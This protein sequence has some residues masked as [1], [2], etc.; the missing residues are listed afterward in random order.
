MVFVINV[1]SPS[2]SPPLR[3]WLD[4]ARQVLLFELGG[5]M[6][7]TPLFSWASGVP[8]QQ[9]LVLIVGLAAIAAIWN[10]VFNTG[11]DWLEGRLTGKPADQRPWPMRIVQA[12]CF[13]LGLFVLTLPLVVYWTHLSWVEA[14]LAD[15][16]LA[17]A[18]TVYAFIFNLLYD[19]LFPI[20]PRP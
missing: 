18:Y 6:L 7:V 2:A 12:C 16:G 20:A 8:G 4:R 17:I 5:V 14:A 13:E 1:T 19:R 10:G 3:S 11:F 9:A 15:I